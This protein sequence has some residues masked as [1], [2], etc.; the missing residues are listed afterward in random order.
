ME[1]KYCTKHKKYYRKICLSCN[2]MPSPPNPIEYLSMMNE[3]SQKYWE[4]LQN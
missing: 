4:K 3:K 2:T 1:Q